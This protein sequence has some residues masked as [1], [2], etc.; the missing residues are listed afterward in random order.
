MTSRMVMAYVAMAALALMIS[1][2]VAAHAATKFCDIY[3]ERCQYS[4]NGVHYY[5]P[6]GYRMPGSTVTSPTR[7]V[8][9]LVQATDGH[10]W[11]CGATDGKATGRS[12][13][14]PNQASAS[15]RALSECTKRSTQGSCRVVSCSPS[16]HTYDE[17]HVTWFSGANR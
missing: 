17:A 6:L 15:F 10:A 14:F 1:G 16:V 11:G 8:Q 5:Y 7:P 9:A 4:G 3:P 12:W 2:V 13:G